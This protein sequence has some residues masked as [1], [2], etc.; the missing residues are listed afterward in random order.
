LVRAH[1]TDCG[2]HLRRIIT[3]SGGTLQIG[4]GGTAA[5]S[6]Q[7]LLPILILAFDRSDTFTVANSILALAAH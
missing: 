7:A 2:E 1:D 6:E 5:R 3:I 4:N